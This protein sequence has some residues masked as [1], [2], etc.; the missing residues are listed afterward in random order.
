MGSTPDAEGTN[1][2]VYSASANQDAVMRSVIGSTLIRTRCAQ[3][4]TEA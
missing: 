4:V 3:T 2:A 1:F